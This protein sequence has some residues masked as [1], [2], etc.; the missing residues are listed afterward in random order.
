MA[1]FTFGLSIVL[2]LVVSLSFAQ[3]DPAAGIQLFSTNDF[4][5]DLATSNINVSIPGRS[6]AGKLP[7]SSVFNGNYHVYQSG[8]NWGVN[9]GIAIFVSPLVS[10]HG[11]I[12][13]SCP[14][15]K[16]EVSMSVI[17]GTGASHPFYGAWIGLCSANKNNG[18]W[19]ASDGSGYTLVVTNSVPTVYDINGVQSPMI[20]NLTTGYGYSVSA[21]DP[22]GA[23][24]AFNNTTGNWTD[25]LNTTALTQTYNGT[26]AFTYSYADANGGSP[27]YTLSYASGKYNFASNFQCQGFAEYSGSYAPVVSLTTPTGGKYSF[28][29]EP[30]PNKSGYYTARIAKVINPS[31]GSISYSYSGGNNGINC[32]SGVVPKLTVTLS[33][34]NNNTQS[35]WTYVNNN[36]NPALNCGWPG[37]CN[38]TVVRTD[39]ANNQTVFSFAGGFQ[40]LAQY[41]SGGCPTSINGCTGGGTELRFITTCYN[42]VFSNCATSSTPTPSMPITQTDVYTWM[43]ATPQNLVETKYDPNYGVITSVG[44]WDWGAATP[45]TS[46]GLVRRRIPHSVVGRTA[47]AAWQ[48]A[49]T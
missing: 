32:T 13:G 27:G 2:L 34:N 25:S 38:F 39:P 30:T 4:G 9:S 49:I 33:D 12:S 3:S 24:I 46:A 35:T 41:Y 29:Y 31:G 14:S 21:T 28:S 26:N 37:T 5:I 8:S 16:Q 42:G 11:T 15:Y 48:W 22:D 1:R 43:Q 18:T 10:L 47:Q 36:N 17:D 44:R 7:F 23:S 45:P 20:G 19:T 40:T 6:K